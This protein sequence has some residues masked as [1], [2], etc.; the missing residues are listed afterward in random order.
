MMEV[1]DK[2]RDVRYAGFLIIP[3]KYDHEILN[4]ELIEKHGKYIPVTTM[5][6]NE[7]IKMMFDKYNR[8]SVGKS[9][10][11]NCKDMLSLLNSKCENIKLFVSDDKRCYSFELWDSFLYIFH[12]QVAFLCL[13]ISFDK[14]DSVRMICNPGTAVNPAVFL[15]S[16]GN[17]EKNVFSIENWLAEYIKPLGLS[18]FFDGNSSFLLDA[19]A[20]IYAVVPERFHEL[21]EMQKITFNLHKMLEINAP[22]I[23]NAEEDIRY[24][25]AVKDQN[26]NSYRWG[27]CVASQTI[28]YIFA[29]PKM[30]LKQQ[31]LDH[32]ADGL[33]VVILALYEKYTCLRFTELI[34]NIK[35]VKSNL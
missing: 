4:W 33:P 2:N 30:D 9:Y 23:D 22:F 11:L 25:Y 15:W 6:V 17:G 13:S 7:N 5:D 18:K 12:T 26:H 29:D 19:Y 14:M 35:S 34:T 24:V 3:L 10:Q 32:A 27:C 8:A 28:S 31:Y 1:F 21:D 16:D 20:Y